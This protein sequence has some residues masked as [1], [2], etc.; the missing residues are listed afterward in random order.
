MLKSSKSK[1]L[2][3]ILIV[4]LSVPVSAAKYAGEIFHYGMG[5][6]NLALGGTGLTNSRSTSLAWW[7]PALLENVQDN[8][9]EVMHAEDYEGL[10]KYDNFSAIWGKYKKLAVSLSRIA[11]NDIPLT[12]LENDSLDISND[13]RPYAYDYVTNSDLVLFLG[14]NHK[15]RNYSFGFTP[16]LAYRKLANENAFGFGADVSFFKE[17]KPELLLA[18][19]IRDFFTTSVFWSN[20]TSESVYPSSNIELSYGCLMPF[21]KIYARSFLR[22]EIFF[23]G[24]EEAATVSVA[25]ASADF[26]AGMQ[27]DVAKNL[28]I[29]AGFDVDHFT[30]GFAGSYRKFQLIYAFALETELDNSHR[31]AL[32]WSF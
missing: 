12:K 9:L 29:L 13:N 2:L 11:I 5:V 24:R 19:Q 14:F 21:L 4:S 6:R 16:K 8:K 17:I 18:L 10:L 7:N 27:I 30:C 1:W 26:H 15:I 23:E 20:G 32:N 22:T 31:V 28:E 3:L 25:P